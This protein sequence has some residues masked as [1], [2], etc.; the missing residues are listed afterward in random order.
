MKSHL[1]ADTLSPISPSLSGGQRMELLDPTHRGLH[2]FLVFRIFGP[3]NFFLTRN[4]MISICVKEK[5]IFIQ[6]FFRFLPR[7]TDEIEIEIGDPVYVQ[8]DYLFEHF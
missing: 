5:D 6:F 4:T 3:L 1:I 2:R 8:V 7:H